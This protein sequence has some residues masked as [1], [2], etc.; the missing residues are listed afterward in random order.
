MTYPNPV[1]NHSPLLQ[2][3]MFPTILILTV[4]A[5]LSSGCSNDATSQAERAPAPTAVPAPAGIGPDGLRRTLEVVDGGASTGLVATDY[6]GFAVYGVSGET[7]EALVCVGGCTTAWIPLAPRDQA[8]SDELDVAKLA[9]F[10]RPDG[11][12]QAVYDGIP[13][14]LWTGD[15]EIGITGGAGVAG[16]WFALTEAGGLL[17][18]D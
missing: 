14:Y 5:V 12:E 13:L 8:A 4:V 3:R 11:I 7:Q 10:T 2:I 18:S 6:R 9:F 16:T 1:R 17:A 15:S